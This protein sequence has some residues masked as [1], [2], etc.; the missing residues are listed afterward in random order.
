MYKKNLSHVYSIHKFFCE[1]HIEGH[2]TS[3]LRHADVEVSLD[4]VLVLRVAVT[5]LELLV[6]LTDLVLVLLV[7]LTDLVLLGC[8]QTSFL[9]FRV[10]LKNHLRLLRVLKYKAMR[11]LCPMGL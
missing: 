10:S 4:E 8:T 7:P 3:D 2:V 6:L 11:V 5:D 9:R 1:C